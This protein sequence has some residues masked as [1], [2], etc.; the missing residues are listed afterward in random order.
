MRRRTFIAV[1]RSRP[2]RAQAQRTRGH[3][4]ARIYGAQPVAEAIGASKTKALVLIFFVS[5][6]G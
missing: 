4:T 2:Q 5:F 6:A 1:C 3:R